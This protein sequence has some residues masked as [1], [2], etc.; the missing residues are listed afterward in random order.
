MA[1]HWSKCVV[2]L[3]WVTAEWKSGRDRSCNQSY[4]CVGI[5]DIFFFLQ[6]LVVKPDQLLKRRGKLGLV[7]VNANLK[8]VQEWVSER[9]DTEFTVDKAVGKL[10]NFIVEPFVAHK[11]EEEF[12]VRWDILCLC[13]VFIFTNTSCPVVLVK[14]SVFE[15]T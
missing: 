5:H 7:K 9:M 2:T 4:V 3:C 8:E 15:I 12:Y 13:A 11:Q 10:N 6:P 14:N 1:G